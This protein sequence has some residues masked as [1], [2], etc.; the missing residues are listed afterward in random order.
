LVK[1]ASGSAADAS[2]LVSSGAFCWLSL[3]ITFLL[4]GRS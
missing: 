1:S 3:D 2:E 4:L